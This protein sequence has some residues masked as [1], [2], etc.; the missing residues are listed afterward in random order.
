MHMNPRRKAAKFF[1]RIFGISKLLLK[2]Y[3]LAVSVI[4]GKQFRDRIEVIKPFFDLYFLAG[5]RQIRLGDPNDGGYILDAN[6]DSVDLCLS[7]G[8][9][10]NTRFED[11]ISRFVERVFMFDHTI[12]PPALSNSNMT[13]FRKGLGITSS[14]DFFTLSEIL[15]FALPFNDA[16][17]KIDIGGAVV[18]VL[19]TLPA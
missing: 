7:F 2:L 10:D 6:L 18:E 9:G 5:S 16:I 19:T 1:L 13:F 17:L 11:D 8:I 14:L 15:E 4:L 12:Q 3:P